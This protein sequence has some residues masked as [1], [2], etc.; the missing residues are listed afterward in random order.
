MH[1][2]I[3]GLMYSFTSLQALVYKEGSK[4]NGLGLSENHLIDGD[5][6]DYAGLFN[7]DGY[8]LIKRN[9]SYGKGEGF[10]M[11]VKNSI[12][13]KRRQDLENLLL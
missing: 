6:I 8:T 12:K 13:F 7:I 10:A 4:I 2:N 1:Q 9:R 3:R 11:Y 5:K